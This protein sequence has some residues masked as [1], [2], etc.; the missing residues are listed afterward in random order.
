VLK[1]ERQCLE[2][3]T[4]ARS[5]HP[6]PQAVAEVCVLWV[7]IW[8]MLDG[9][10]GGGVSGR[11]GEVFRGSGFISRKGGTGNCSRLISMSSAGGSRVPLDLRRVLIEFSPRALSAFGCS[12]T[13]DVTGAI[14]CGCSKGGIA[15]ISTSGTC[16]AAMGTKTSAWFAGGRGL[17][18]CGGRPGAFLTAG[19]AILGAGAFR[20]ILAFFSASF[21]FAFASYSCFDG[22]FSLTRWTRE[23]SWSISFSFSFSVEVDVLLR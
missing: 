4:A 9:G 6:P 16:G 15:A 11:G 23:V 8:L 21:A 22:M 20:G 18:T 1:Q 17:V 10:G 13:K 7:A 19:L 5:G 14:G 3:A 12:I 2:E